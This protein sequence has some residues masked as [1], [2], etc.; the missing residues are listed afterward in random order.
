MG[1]REACKVPE[2]GYREDLHGEAEWL[3]GSKLTLPSDVHIYYFQ[4]NGIQ[5]KFARELWERI[6]RECGI[7][8]SCK[9]IPVTLY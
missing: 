3:K 9:S 4:N 1:S 5:K 6:R 7:N 8:C 2:F